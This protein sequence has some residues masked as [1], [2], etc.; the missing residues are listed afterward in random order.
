MVGWVILITFSYLVFL[1]DR[2]TAR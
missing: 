2:H 1:T